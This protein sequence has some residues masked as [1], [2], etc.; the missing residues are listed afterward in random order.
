MTGAA[1]FED[2]LS[3]LRHAAAGT[4]CARADIPFRSSREDPL[5]VLLT[6]PTGIKQRARHPDLIVFLVNNF[7]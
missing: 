6:E 3:H 1:L 4:Q 7:F 2:E 5:C